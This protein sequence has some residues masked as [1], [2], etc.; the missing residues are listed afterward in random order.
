MGAGAGEASLRSSW[1]TDT[2]RWS[3]ATPK[4]AMATDCTSRT[5]C[6]G[7]FEGVARM[8]TSIGAPA[9]STTTRAAVTS[10]IRHSARSISRAS[11]VTGSG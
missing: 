5:T 6:L 3:M 10:G 2:T 9:A 7:A 1:T 11:V 8:W 4:V